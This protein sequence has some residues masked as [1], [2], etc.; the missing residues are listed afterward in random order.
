[1]GG[2][3]ENVSAR[4]PAQTASSSKLSFMADEELRKWAKAYG[5]TSKDDRESLLASLV[6]VVKGKKFLD[7]CRK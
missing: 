6:R 2:A 3:G 7:D 1:M 4:G 5:L